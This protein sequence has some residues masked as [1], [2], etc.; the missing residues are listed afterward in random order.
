MTSSL[1]SPS[2]PIF[3][4]VKV[5]YSSR[6]AERFIQMRPFRRDSHR[7]LFYRDV[8]RRR[9]RNQMPALA[10]SS[11]DQGLKG[12]GRSQQRE[13]NEGHGVGGVTA[14]RALDH[15]RGCVTSS[16]FH[17]RHR[18]EAGR[19]IYPRGRWTNDQTACHSHRLVSYNKQL[20]SLHQLIR[21]ISITQLNHKTSSKCRS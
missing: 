20:N 14:S 10:F 18:L 11:E 1:P 21:S 16:L 8:I 17:S 4:C 6:P 5:R 15:V 13:P 2:H 19:Y 9:R 3:V 12:Q 7:H